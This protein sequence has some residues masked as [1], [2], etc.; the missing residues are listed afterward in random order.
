[1]RFCVRKEER[2]GK[3]K[4][5]KRLKLKLSNLSKMEKRKR[6]E[7]NK[8]NEK[9]PPKDK[10]NSSQRFNKVLFIYEINISHIEMN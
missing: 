4:R 3:R 1:M 6:S 8:I 10:K 5:Q 7:R 9:A 2:E